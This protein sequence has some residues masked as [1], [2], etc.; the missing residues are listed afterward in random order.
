MECL[1]GKIEHIQQTHKYR[2]EKIIIHNGKQVDLGD[3]HWWIEVDGRIIDPYFQQYDAIKKY[4]NL[5]GNCIYKKL[6]DKTLLIEYFKFFNENYLQKKQ[7]Q[8]LGEIVDDYFYEN[9]VFGNCYIN[10]VSY[11]KKQGGKLVCGS[12]GWKYQ[13]SDQVWYEFG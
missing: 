5:V 10:A 4:H 2:M 12:L 9:P 6:E 8:G 1:I 7:L 13:N 3:I 11:K